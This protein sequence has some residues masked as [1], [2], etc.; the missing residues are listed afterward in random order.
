MQLVERH[1]EE[2]ED[3]VDEPDRVLLLHSG[4]VQHE[5]HQGDHVFQSGP[6]LDLPGARRVQ[7]EGH[8]GDLVFPS[9]PE[10]DLPGARRVQH[11]DLRGDRLIP[12]GI[13][14]ARLAQPNNV[15][16]DFLPPGGPQIDDHGDEFGEYLGQ[17]A[18]ELLFTS[19]TNH[20]HSLLNV[21]F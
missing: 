14:V 13:D 20:Y 3:M 8:L 1:L 9:G 4:A 19:I 12:P 18:S 21:K 5:G 16:G 7:Q 10:I 2:L 6:E 11:E 15:H 17:H